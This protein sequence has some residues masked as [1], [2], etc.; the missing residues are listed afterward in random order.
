MSSPHPYS[1]LPQSRAR[2]QRIAEAAVERARLTVV[3]RAKVPAR[4]VP[5]VTLVSLML[6]G[7]VVGLL[8]FNT[9]MQQD[10]FTAASLETKATD[11]T[12]R[13][14]TLQMQLE[15]LR[16]PQRLA[17]K[18]TKLGMVPATSPAFIRLADGKVLGEPRPASA[19]DSFDIRTPVVKKPAAL[20]PDPVVIKTRARNRGRSGDTGAASPD[21]G[22]RTGRNGATTR[23]QG[24]RSTR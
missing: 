22:V 12:S 24:D 4:R 9:T 2:V 15:K 17:E 23:N 8:M 3:P 5:F 1:R 20:T 10:S 19:E 16:D 11:L 13:E 6:V 14:Q 7:G 18:A 21:A